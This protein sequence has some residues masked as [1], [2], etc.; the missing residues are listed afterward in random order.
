MGSESI[1]I[2]SALQSSVFIPKA[3][4]QKRYALEVPGGETGKAEDNGNPVGPDV[5]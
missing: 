5:Y 2:E 4:T 3:G 1:R